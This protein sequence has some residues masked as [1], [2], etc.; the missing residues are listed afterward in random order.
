MRQRA[1]WRRGPTCIRLGCRVRP[2]AREGGGGGERWQDGRRAVS[3]LYATIA[4]A[5]LMPHSTDTPVAQLKASFQEPTCSQQGKTQ[6]MTTAA[7]IWTAT[8]LSGT[9]EARILLTIVV[10]VEHTQ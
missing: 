7:A 9:T 1:R 8:T 6:K 4:I 10:A 5:V 3:H 2:R